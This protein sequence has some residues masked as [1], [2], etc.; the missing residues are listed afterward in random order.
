MRLPD[1][2]ES[3]VPHRGAM[4]LVDRVVAVDADS[5]EAEAEVRA[6]EPIMEVE[7]VPA[8]V[9][10]EYMAQ[11]IAAW[12]GCR[13]RAR[14]AEPQLGF[15]LGTRRY[16]CSV[17]HFPIGSRLRIEARCEM[18]GANGL[19]QFA[20]RILRDGRELAAA[21]VSV[22]EPPDAQAFLDA[23]QFTATDRGDER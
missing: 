15:L 12:A 5:V 1:D 20:C 23:M 18:L 8:W 19:A 6:D 22:F 16:E 2:I 17:S 7:G 9:G 3:V 21:N 10:I 13:A 4:R 14:G 11:T